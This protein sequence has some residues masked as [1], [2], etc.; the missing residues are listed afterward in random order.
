MSDVLG[1]ESLVDT[2][3]HV[4][5]SKEASI[6]THSAILGPFYRDGLRTQAHDTTIVRQPD[7]PEAYTYLHGQV[8]G[9]DGKPLEGATIDIWHDASDGLYDSQSPDKPEFNCRGRFLSDSDGRYSL[10][11]LKV[12]CLL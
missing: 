9:S 12:I 1:I 4:R 10:V 5:T 2:L 6:S 11:C 7:D 3:A 8:F